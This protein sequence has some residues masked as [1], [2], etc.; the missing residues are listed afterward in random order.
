MESAIQFLGDFEDEQNM[1]N[2]ERYKKAYKVGRIKKCVE[3]LIDI[4]ISD[5]KNF[6]RR[7]LLSNALISPFSYKFDEGEY[8]KTKEIFHNAIKKS[9]G[10]NLKKI[11]YNHLKKCYFTQSY[12]MKITNQ[13]QNVCKIVNF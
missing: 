12:F 10:F 7:F 3:I 4:G 6:K 5:S 13:I 8:K 1:D 11:T 9:K 2:I